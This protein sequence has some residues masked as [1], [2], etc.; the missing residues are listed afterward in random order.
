MTIEE[1]NNL[2][3]E[4]KR[5]IIFEANKICEEQNDY[6]K[7]ELFYIPDVFIETKTS[8]RYNFKRTISTYTLYTLP[9]VYV[10]NVRM[11]I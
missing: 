8:M 5:V 9:L 1:F 4:T 11:A 10:A 2:D 6:T 7:Y 3:E